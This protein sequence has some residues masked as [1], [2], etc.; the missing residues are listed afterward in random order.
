MLI[1][2]DV[3]LG[4]CI[5]Y[6]QHSFQKVFFCLLCVAVALIIG[7]LTAYNPIASVLFLLLLIGVCLFV[8]FFNNTHKLLSIW[9]PIMPIT[10]VLSVS[11]AEKKVSLIDTATLFVGF[12]LLIRSS[13]TRKS[14]EN[15]LTKNSV[16]VLVSLFF[17]FLISF[18]LSLYGFYTYKD[19]VVTPVWLDNLNS[20]LK[21]SLVTNVRLFIPFLTIFIMVRLVKTQEVLH[22]GLKLFFLS[23]V[24]S[25]LYGYYELIIKS[26]GL[27]FNMLLPG[28]SQSILYFDDKT[29]LSGMFGDPS[30]YAGYIVMSA[31]FCLFLKDL[32]VFPRLITYVVL[33]SQFVLLF[34]T[35]STIGWLSL[36]TGIVVYFVKKGKLK[37]IFT[38]LVVSF[39]LFGVLSLN[40]TFRTVL[41]KPF[42]SDNGSRSD[43]MITAI[44]ALNIFK[45]NPILGVG[46]GNYGLVYDKYRPI[47]SEEKEFQPI[48]NNVYL[49]ILSA[50]GIVGTFL[51]LWIA[52]SLWSCLRQI[53]RHDTHKVY[54]PFFIA[55]TCSILVLFNAYPTYNFAF[56][57]FFYGMIL[58]TPKILKE[59]SLYR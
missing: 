26:L 35:Y 27:G 17:I 30:Y 48:A 1:Y 25:T 2:G 11:V 18:S 32:K 44:T 36:L 28:H 37:H 5:L 6:L 7:I 41:Y 51:F 43:R 14:H 49:D 46:N 45:D 55:T 12:V 29:R 13:I 23:I 52:K 47:G 58:V 38:L 40:P 20:I 42:D 33:L 24:F 4:G 16:S 59:A 54:Y 9:L 53:K 50:Y 8:Y 21:N 19:V 31:F 57:W 56:H 15:T 34:F 39:I 3:W 22:K 10:S